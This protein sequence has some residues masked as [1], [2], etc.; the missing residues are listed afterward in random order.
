MSRRVFCAGLDASSPVLSEPWRG[1]RDVKT[2][3]SVVF[4]LG[5]AE[6]MP[7][8]KLIGRMGISEQ[9]FYR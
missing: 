5:R 3:E 7:V 4:P 8:T 6:R 1:S 2:G 9:K